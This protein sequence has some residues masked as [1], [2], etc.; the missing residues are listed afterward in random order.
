MTSSAPR[1]VVVCGLDGVGMRTVEQLHSAGVPVVAVDPDPDPRR[2]EVLAGWDVPLVAGNPRLPVTWEKADLDGALAVLCVQGGDLDTLATALLAR[3]LRPDVRLVVRFGNTA[4]GA[5]MAELTGQASVLD[6]PSLVA[7]V[8]IEDCLRRR[9]HELDIAGE[10]FVVTSVAPDETGSLRE[11]FGDLAPVAVTRGEQVQLCPG[12]DEQAGPADRVTL[13]GTP[14][15]LAAAGVL[16]DTQRS[17]GRR[18]RPVARLA[19][20]LAT[21]VAETDRSFRATL[22][23]LLALVVVSTVVLRF[24]YRTAAGGHLS[25]FDSAYFTMETIATVGFGDFSFANQPTWVESFGLLLIVLGAGLISTAFALL[26]NL[27]VSRRLEAS[28]G[29]RRATTMRGHV[30]LVGL[31][32][33]GLRVLDGLL[34]RGRDVLVVERDE[35]N[36]YL[37]QVR[38][39]GIQVLIGDSTVPETLAAVGVAG[40]SAV[41]VLTS[42]EL[43]NIE[44]G[45]AVKQQLAERFERVPV[46]LRV[47]DRHLASTVAGS[48]GFHHVRSISV[49]AAPWFVGA[50]LGL[51]VLGIFTVADQPLLVG[52]L[53]VAAAGG[54]D[55][56]AMQDLSE[57][58]R[59]LAI[60]RA[61]GGL[62]HPPRRDT[63]F[64]AGD[65]AYLVGPYE[66]L[67]DVLRRDQTALG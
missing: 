46:V 6:V 29:R 66:E 61:G 63:R 34:D 20:V 54:L 28:L 38:A 10:Q 23:F 11:L 4:L 17:S 49:L 5:A 65:A 8:L 43:T 21:F 59:V 67:L 2:A 16:R 19:R 48:F 9:E 58:T 51:E 47:F 26:T 22:G 36:R 27:L 33:V 55:G 35:G 7:P 24:G 32:S 62:E 15:D 3:E 12:R 1:H 60:G 57:R 25:T 30:V 40:A 44:T 13:V 18:R 56:L 39:R 52:R 14:A 37:A 53:V 64:A 50:A 45:I 31:G 41:A 42:D